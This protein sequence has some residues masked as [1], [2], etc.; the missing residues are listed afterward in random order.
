MLTETIGLFNNSY[1]YILLR[2]TREK[3][4]ISLFKKKKRVFQGKRII[5][6]F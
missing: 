2:N 5:K 3:N 6:L 4:V 1:F